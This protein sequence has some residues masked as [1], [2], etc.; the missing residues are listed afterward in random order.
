MEE[1]VGNIWD[2][3][4]R[5]S[6]ED[7][8]KYHELIE[9]SAKEHKLRQSQPEPHKCI[10]VQTVSEKSSYLVMCTIFLKLLNKSLNV[11]RRVK[12]S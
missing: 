8:Q 7:P 4:S 9:Q 1:V 2:N 11:F 6:E 10:S 5:L 12:P 3:L